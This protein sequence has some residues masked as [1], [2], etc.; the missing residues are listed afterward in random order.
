[1]KLVVI[2]IFMVSTPDTYTQFRKDVETRCK[3]R[4]EKRM[5]DKLK[6]FPAALDGISENLP[7]LHDLK[8]EGMVHDTSS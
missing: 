6:P 5:P 2:V 1:M 7:S 4:T 8:L 3:I